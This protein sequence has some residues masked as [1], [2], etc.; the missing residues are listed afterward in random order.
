MAVG[1]T[2][3]K[4]MTG[5]LDNGATDYCAP[6]TLK[7]SAF[8]PK[9]EILAAD[10]AQTG[11]CFMGIGLDMSDQDTVVPGLYGLVRGTGELCN[12]ASD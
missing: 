5:L 7:R 3:Q 8:Q 2:F 11:N 6:R 9:T 10:I 4:Y 1:C 12:G